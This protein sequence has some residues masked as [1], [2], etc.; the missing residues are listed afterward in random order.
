MVGSC[1]CKHIVTK[2]MNKVA[3]L[4]PCSKEVDFVDHC[5]LYEQ[6]TWLVAC[7]R[8]TRKSQSQGI[9]LNGLDQIN[10]VNL[11]DEENYKLVFVIIDFCCNL[12]WDK[13]LTFL[14]R[15]FG[16]SWDY[17]LS[18]NPLKFGLITTLCIIRN[19][20]RPSVWA[21]AWVKSQVC[22]TLSIFWGHPTRIS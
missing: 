11:R 22:E 12:T 5:R 2:P 8:P 4:V 14:R 16:K 7:L 15:I 1:T 6:G 10:E 3:K 19:L 21:I 9:T 13:Q 17:Q 18:Q 20:A